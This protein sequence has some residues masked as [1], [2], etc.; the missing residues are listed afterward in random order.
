[1]NSFLL[2]SP[3][4]HPIKAIASG[5]YTGYLPKAPGS[6]GSLLC[7]CILWFAWP[8]AWYFQ[9]PCIF[10]LWILAEFTAGLAEHIYGHDDRH[11]VIDEIAGQAVT[12][13]MVPHSIISFLLAFVLF[14]IFDIVKL[15]PAREWEKLPGGRGVVADDMAAGLYAAVLLQMIIAFMK[16]I[17]VEWIVL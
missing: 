16:G 8:T 2:R 15:P 1:M 13:F 12:L 17:G 14:R 9:L 5:F 6:W 11:I 7:C 4:V 3:F 10:G